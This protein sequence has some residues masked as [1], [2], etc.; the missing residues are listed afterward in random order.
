MVKK[1]NLL[2]ASLSILVLLSLFCKKEPDYPE[3]INVSNN[4]GRSEWPSIAVD[5][6]GTVHLVWTDDTPYGQAA[7]DQQI[8]YAFKPKG[9]SWSIPVNV[10]NTRYSARFPSIVVDKD[11]R[12]HLAWQQFLDLNYWW[13]WVIFYSQKSE[14]GEWTPPETIWAPAPPSE[15]KLAIDSLGNI[16]MIF[17]VSYSAYRVDLFYT[18]KTPQT[19]WTRPVGLN[20]PP[21]EPVMDPSIGVSKKG[22]VNIIW[23]AFFVRN[24]SL[25]EEEIF[26]TEKPAGQNWISPINISNTYETSHSPSLAV[27][28]DNNVHIVWIDCQFSSPIGAE[29]AYRSRLANG[30]WTPIEIIWPEIIDQPTTSH[31]IIVADNKVHFLWQ[32]NYKDPYTG[33]IYYS[34]RTENNWSK[35]KV[36]HKIGKDYMGVSWMSFVGDKEGVFHITYSQ[37]KYGEEENDVYYLEYKYDK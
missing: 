30:E 21:R 18:M 15:P 34:Q 28:P 31:Y 24:D 3:P 27:D 11:D 33:G 20:P 12:L 1:N 7:G 5:S 9:G 10:S 19:G 23:E 22:D 37:H 17:C 6:K 14:S 35:P 25:F 32:D 36:I 4:P 16:H 13:G 8:L 26:Y 29:Y 2:L